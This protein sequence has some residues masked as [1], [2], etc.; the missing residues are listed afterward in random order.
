[1]ITKGVGCNLFDR[2]CE[3]DIWSTAI[4]KTDKT[5]P[6]NAKYYGIEYADMSEGTLHTWYAISNIKNII[7]RK[8]NL[9]CTV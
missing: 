9:L 4:T 3:L 8:T 7:D 2:D 1:M 6:D 5:P